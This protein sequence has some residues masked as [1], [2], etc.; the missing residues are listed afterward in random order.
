MY[1]VYCDKCG[2]EI[3]Q[4]IDGINLDFNY[5][6]SVKFVNSAKENHLNLCTECAKKVLKFIR[7]DKEREGNE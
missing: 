6:G 3:D 7:A 5:Y 2:R 4:E 1:K